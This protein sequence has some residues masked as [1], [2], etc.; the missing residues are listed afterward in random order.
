MQPARLHGRP[1]PSVCYY[2]TSL[3][4]YASLFSAV[5]VGV[6]GAVGYM[7]WATELGGNAAVM[8]KPAAPVVSPPTRKAEPTKDFIVTYSAQPLWLQRPR[9]TRSP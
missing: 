2:H 6:M 3:I 7:A 5:A 1:Q 8:E 4:F 9:E